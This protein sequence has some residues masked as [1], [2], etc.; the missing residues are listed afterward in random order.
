M[1]KYEL[2]LKHASLPAKNVQK[3]CNFCLFEP[4][5]MGVKTGFGGKCAKLCDIWIHKI[6]SRKECFDFGAILVLLLACLFILPT[7]LARSQ[8]LIFHVVWHSPTCIYGLKL[9]QRVKNQGKS[10]DFSL[11][12]SCFAMCTFQKLW[13]L[14]WLCVMA[15]WEVE[16]YTHVY[17]RITAISYF[18]LSQP[19]HTSL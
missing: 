9:G 8:F 19:S 5:W 13:I 12:V 10:E 2:F 4:N 17:A 18:L 11:F 6:V 3:M 16:A 15:I 1:Q 14:S 7:W